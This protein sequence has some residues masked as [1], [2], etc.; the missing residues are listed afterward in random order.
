MTL[1]PWSKVVERVSII[2]DR[3]TAPSF[4]Y[5]QTKS[6]R[7]GHEL[8]LRFRRPLDA[9]ANSLHSGRGLDAAGLAAQA[10]P[11][12]SVLP[13]DRPAVLFS[14]KSPFPVLDVNDAWLSICGFT[15]EEVIGQTMKII[16]GPR[17]GAF[18]PARRDQSRPSAAHPCSASSATPPIL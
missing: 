12:S 6:V 17:T 10:C 1:L 4:K 18:R 5:L 11:W 8:G 2:A 7:M 15:R 13:K 16:Q 3:L 14:S 9:C